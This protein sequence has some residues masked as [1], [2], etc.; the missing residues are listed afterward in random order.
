MYFVVEVSTQFEVYEMPVSMSYQCKVC[1][2][3]V[4]EIIVKKRVLA[5]DVNKNQKKKKKENKHTYIK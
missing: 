2:Y 1:S 4:M 5:I 3:N